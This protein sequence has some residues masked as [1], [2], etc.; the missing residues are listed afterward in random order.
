[1]LELLEIKAVMRPGCI[2]VCW[3]AILAATSYPWG[4][5]FRAT[6]EATFQGSNEQVSQATVFGARP[7]YLWLTKNQ[8]KIRSALD[9]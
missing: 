6:V 7:K 9:K 3:Q 2:H 5:L 8:Q 4:L 1:M